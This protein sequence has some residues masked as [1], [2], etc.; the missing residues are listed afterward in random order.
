M[1]ITQRRREAQKALD[2]QIEKTAEARRR[3]RLLERLCERR[4]A[5]WQKA[6]D[7]E[8]EQQAAENFLLRWKR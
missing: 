8:M 2:L 5:E 7:R 3:A 1:Q 6:S 4:W